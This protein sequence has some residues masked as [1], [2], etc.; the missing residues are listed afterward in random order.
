MNYSAVN[1]AMQLVQLYLVDD[2]ISQVL[3]ENDLPHT[4]NMLISIQNLRRDAP[5]NLGS[6]IEMFR[7]A[8]DP[9]QLTDQPANGP[10]TFIHAGMLQVRNRD[11]DDSN[12]YD[13]TEFLLRE[14]VNAY[15]YNLREQTKNFGILIQQVGL[16]CH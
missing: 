15:S 13:K 7:Y 3:S 8:H 5:A 4:I 9:T 2:R 11:Y 16:V 12:L 1:F 10:F 6:L 14:W